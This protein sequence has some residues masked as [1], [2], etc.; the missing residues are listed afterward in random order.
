MEYVKSDERRLGPLASAYTR[1]SSRRLTVLTLLVIF[2]VLFAVTP[3]L[4]TL[5]PAWI[6]LWYIVGWIVAPL[7]SGVIA[8]RVAAQSDGSARKAWRCIGLACLL[9]MAGTVIWV[10]FG[11]FGADLLFPSIADA[12]YLTC[13]VFLMVGTFHYCLADSPGRRIQMTNFALALC[14]TIAVGFILYGTVLFGSGIGWLGAAIAFAYPTL[15]LGAWTFGLVCFV[16]YISNERR[17]PFLLI[18]I[19]TGAFAGA[20]YFYGLD[21]LNDVYAI[22]TFYD[23]LW[24][25]A[26]AFIGWAALE[27]RGAGTVTAEPTA[28]PEQAPRPAEALIPALTVAAILAAGA[29]A[30]WGELRPEHIFVL[31]TL[32]GFAALLT[33]R[34]YA[35][36]GAERTLRHEL[37]DRTLQLADSKAEL[38]AVLASTT[39]GVLSMDTDWRVTYANQNAIDFFFSGRA[40][41]GISHWKL[42]PDL[43]GSKID[44]LYRRAMDRQA[45]EKIDVYYARLGRSFEVHAHPTPE[46]LTIFLRDVTAQRRVEDRFR[47]V[48]QASSDFIFDRDLASNQ[49]WVNDAASWLPDYTPGA[50]EVPRDAWV[51]SVHPDDS[52]EILS[53]IEAAI[54]SGQD[55]WEGEYRL[56]KRDGEYIPVR[57]RASIL[58]NDTG[59]PVRLVGNIIDLSEQKALEAQLRQSQRL[60]AV[61]QLTGGIAHDFNNLLTVILGNAEALADTLPA[62]QPNATLARQI[63]IASER[64]AHLTQHLLAFARKQPL[65]PS[66]FDANKLVEGMRML[67]ERSITPAI[68]LE[69]ELAESLGAVNVDRALFESALLNLCVNARDAMPGGGILRIETCAS[70]LAESAIPDAPAAGEYVR[71]A[72][73]D[74]GNGM[75]EDARDR[76]FEP[77]FTTKPAGEG[78]GLGLSM[79]HGFVHQSGGHV[80]IHSSLGTGTT[81]ELLLPRHAPPADHHDAQEVESAARQTATRARILVVDDE[82]QVREYICMIVRSLGYE[83]EAE[84]RATTAL[85]RLRAGEPF[86]LL[87]SDVVMPGGVSGGQLAATV[88][89]ERPGL[90]VLLVSGHAEEFAAPDGQLDPRIRFLRKPFR[91]SELEHRLAEMLPG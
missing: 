38:S 12:F 75:D 81:V 14:A 84:P 57:E 11:W 58:R 26:F 60:D 71:I 27:H 86:D 9:W 6:D 66:V 34:E 3:S 20:N 21:I 79:V 67:I 44:A 72:V 39:D 28:H 40:F 52:K 8:L 91:K 53:Q 37:E 33:L 23:V 65:S 31:P 5:G 56:R 32:L 18:L 63:M 90:P 4:L 80:R 7:T 89:E 59:E 1:R 50:H 55:F 47:H 19:A 74:T 16:L 2:L 78:S 17:F 46:K 35:L 43:V 77:F 64:A 15:G 87:L 82:D 61:G 25:A 49:T 70:S 42:L 69:M 85:V 10:G 83:V 54:E 62:D 88:L 48:A 30:R 45:P 24:I 36:I 41:L 68:T 76:A 51:D 13:T 22:G 29:A 73:S